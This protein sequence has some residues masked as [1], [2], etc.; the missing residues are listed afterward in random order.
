MSKRTRPIP[1][2]LDAETT[3]RVDQAS[4]R[5]GSNKSSVIRLA[6]L[7]QLEAIESGVIRLP[8]PRR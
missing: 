4:R 3:R 5:L 7:T 6:L 2:R 1:V 8:A